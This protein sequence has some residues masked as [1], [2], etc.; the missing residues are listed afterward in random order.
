MKSNGFCAFRKNILVKIVS[1]LLVQTFLF[2]NISFATIDDRGVSAKTDSA[3]VVSLDNIGISTQ[4]GTIK[5]RYRGK[6]S[7]LIIHIQD[8]H[9]NY[10]AQT[11]ISKILEE[12]IKNY[13]ID[14]VAVEGA[15]GVVDT[16]WFKAFPDAEIRRE[17]ADYFMKKGEITGAEF[18]S[19]TSDYP[20]TIYGAENRDYYV[21]NLN[22]FLESYP[23]KDE[24]VKYYSDVKTALSRFKKYIY[25]KELAELDEK[26][27]EHKRKEI[28]FADYARYLGGLAKSKKIDTNQYENFKI[29]TETLKLEKDINFD[30][31]NEERA[32]LIDKL[33][34]TLEKDKLSELVNKSLEFK[35]GKID[36]NKFYAFLAELAKE[37]KIS[38]TEEYNNLARY[39]IY[40]RIY[41]K[42]EHEKLF[43]E[44]ESLV[45][46]IKERMFVNDDQRTLD[47]FWTN[48]N[49]II[50]FINIELS[51]KEYEYYLANKQD[52]A[53][54]KFIDFINKNAT[55]FGLAYEAKEAPSELT[56]VFPKL[57]D[58]YEIALKRDD[59]LLKNVL[60]GMDKSK[61]KAAVLITGGFHT[62]GISNLLE[63]KGLSYLVIS[64]VIT[65]DAESPYI[66]VL[67]GQKTPFEELLVET[68]KETSKLATWLLS[69]LF[70]EHVR[71]VLKTR[72]AAEFKGAWTE[73]YVHEWF[74]DVL[75]AL[76]RQGVKVS[77]RTIVSG[78]LVDSVR[79]GIAR[80]NRDKRKPVIDGESENRIV[81]IIE[82]RIDELFAEKADTAVKE[83]AQTPQKITSQ[84]DASGYSAK[85]SD[86]PQNGGDTAKRAPTTPNLT[87]EENERL[88]SIVDREKEKS[89]GAIEYVDCP[90]E[91]LQLIKNSPTRKKYKKDLLLELF[92]S[93]K[94][95]IGLIDK[96]KELLFSRKQARLLGV[97]CFFDRRRDDKR[98]L[99]GAL[100]FTREFW[101][102]FVEGDEAN[103][104][105]DP[106]FTPVTKYDVAAA[107]VHEFASK[108]QR[109]AEIGTRHSF[110]TNAELCVNS[111][112]ADKR[113]LSD[114]DILFLTYAVE[115]H[116]IDYLF[117]ALRQYKPAKD[118]TDSFN[119]A[120]N[121]TIK[122][123]AERISNEEKSFAGLRLNETR[124]L[125]LFIRHLVETGHTL[126]EIRDTLLKLRN[127]DKILSQEVLE[128]NVFQ[129]DWITPGEEGFVFLP[130]IKPRT[131][132]KDFAKIELPASKDLE[133]KF[134]Q[135]IGEKEKEAEAR[136]AAYINTPE[137]DGKSPQAKLLELRTKACSTD[138]ARA[139]TE[140]V[141]KAKRTM[142]VVD[143]ADAQNK[144]LLAWNTPEWGIYDTY[145]TK[146]GNE[147]SMRRDPLDKARKN[148]AMLNGS[149]MADLI[150]RQIMTKRLEQVRTGSGHE[151]QVIMIAGAGGQGKSTLAQ[152]I[153]KKLKAYIKQNPTCGLTDKDMV[154][155]GTDHHLFETE[156]RYRVVF[157]ENG[158]KE[159][160]P[161]IIGG[162][163]YE[164]GE[165]VGDLN[166]LIHGGDE[167]YGVPVKAKGTDKHAGTIT[168][169]HPINPVPIIIVE[170][171]TAINDPQ[172]RNNIGTLIIGIVAESDKTRLEQK[173][174][175]DML[176]IEEGGT[177]GLTEREIVQDALE[178]MI[179]EKNDM[180]A[181]DMEECADIIW[182]PDTS[183]ILLR[184]HT[185]RSFILANRYKWLCNEVKK[186]LAKQDLSEAV[187]ETEA[188]GYIDTVVT[189]AMDKRAPETYDLAVEAIVEVVANQANPG[190]ALK[191]LG[192]LVYEL[193]DQNK[194]KAFHAMLNAVNRIVQ[195]DIP[196]EEAKT[197]TYTLAAHVSRSEKANWIIRVLLSPGV[198]THELGHMAE[199]LMKGRLKLKDIRLSHL[200]KGIPGEVRGPP[201]LA[202]ME[203]NLVFGIALPLLYSYFFQ[204][205]PTLLALYFTANLCVLILDITLPVLSMRFPGVFPS[206]YI[207]QSDLYNLLKESVL[208]YELNESF[209]E[210]FENEKSVLESGLPRKLIN[211]AL[212]VLE[213]SGRKA[214]VKKALKNAAS[215]YPIFARGVLNDAIQYLPDE[216]QAVIISI[217]QEIT[218][219][220]AASKKVVTLIPVGGRG[221]GF[222]PF[223]WTVLKPFTKLFGKSNVKYAAERAIATGTSPKDIFFII[224]EEMIKEAK[225]EVEG[226]GI[227]E[228][229]FIP[230]Y[231]GIDSEGNTV[232]LEKSALLG[233]AAVYISRLRG[234]DTVIVAERS[235]LVLTPKKG[236]MDELKTALERA[237]T[238]AYLEPTVAFLGNPPTEEEL[239]AIASGQKT[240]DGNKGYIVVNPNLGTAMEGVYSV[241]KFHEKP[242]LPDG[243]A[244]SDT[245]KRYLS[246]KASYNA[247]MFIFRADYLLKMF[248]NLRP[249]DY[250]KLTEL[251][252]SI[253]MES[254]REVTQSVYNYFVSDAHK[255][256]KAQIHTAFEKS[257]V[258]AIAPVEGNGPKQ[259]GV[260]VA[261]FGQAVAQEWVGGQGSLRAVWPS[262]KVGENYIRPNTPAAVANIEIGNGVTGCNILLNEGD[263]DTHVHVK[264]AKG[265]AIAYEKDKKAL[266]VAP[267]KSSKQVKGITEFVRGSELLGAFAE[268]SIKS[269]PKA[270]RTD[271]KF[272]TVGTNVETLGLN[273]F[274]VIQASE[275][276][277]VYCEQ[278]IVGM[279]NAENTIVISC[280]EGSGR[281]IYVYGPDALYEGMVKLASVTDFAKEAKTRLTA[282][283]ASIERNEMTPALAKAYA[284]QMGGSKEDF[285]NGKIVGSFRIC[286]ANT[287][288]VLRDDIEALALL[289][290]H[291]NEEIA[292]AAYPSWLYGIGNWLSDFH[293]QREM[294]VHDRVIAQ[295]LQVARKVSG[296][297]WEKLDKNLTEY[298]LMSE[299]D[300][301][302]LHAELGKVQSLAKRGVTDRE[303]IKKIIVISRLKPG[304]DIAMNSVIFT[305]VKRMLPHAEIVFVGAP[306]GEDL[307]GGD[308]AIRLIPIKQ[309]KETVFAARA[310]NAGA[311]REAVENELRGLQKGEEALVFDISVRNT[312]FGVFPALP[313][314]TAPRNYMYYE[315]I[316]E[317]DVTLSEEIDRWLYEIF[318]KEQGSAF[319]R[320]Y[321]Y[322]SVGPKH[323]QLA[324][325]ILRAAHLENQNF[326]TLTLGTGGDESK[327]ISVQFE[328]DLVQ[329]IL[330]TGR[331]VIMSKGDRRE[332]ERVNAVVSEL[333]KRHVAVGHIDGANI[334][335]VT[336]TKTPKVVTVSTTLGGFSALIGKSEQLIC[337]SSAPKHIGGALRVP[338]VVIYLRE[339]GVHDKWIPYTPSPVDVV[340]V[341]PEEVGSKSPKLLA[342]RIAA[343]AMRQKKLAELR[344]TFIS[345]ETGNNVVRYDWGGEGNALLLGKPGEN[346]AE[347]W[348]Y[349]TIP[350]GDKKLPDV[351]AGTAISVGTGEEKVE[352]APITFKE[353]VET[354][355]EIL[356]KRFESVPYFTKSLSPRTKPRVYIAFNKKIEEEGALSEFR[357]ASEIE[358]RL[359][360]ELMGSFKEGLTEA[361]FKNEFLKNY[362]KW[363]E[364]QYDRGWS[365][366]EIT[367]AIPEEIM[368]PGYDRTLWERMRKNR[369][370]L[371]SFFLHTELKDGQIIMAPAGD[372]RGG[373]LHR[374]VGSFQM[375]PYGSHPDAKHE[376]WV[377]FSAGKNPGGEEKFAT[378]EIMNMSDVTLSPF[379][380]DSPLSYKNGKVVPRKNLCGKNLLAIGN[381]VPKA[382]DDSLE[383]ALEAEVE[384]IDIMI[385]ALRP[386]GFE[387]ITSFDITSQAGDVTS[388]YQHVE[389]AKAQSVIEGTYPV[390]PQ[391]L[392]VMH[393]LTLSGKGESEKAKISVEPRGAKGDFEQLLVTKG[394]VTVAR[395]GEP[396]ETL[397][398]GQA[399]FI[400]ADVKDVYTITASSEAE[401]LR[402]YPGKDIGKPVNETEV[403]QKGSS[404]EEGDNG[405]PVA[406]PEEGA[407]KTEEELIV[408]KG[409]DVVKRVAQAFGA[410]LATYIG[411]PC[412][413]FI[414]QGMNL[415]TKEVR[416]YVED[417]YGVKNISKLRVVAFSRLDTLVGR[418]PK[419]AHAII[420]FDTELDRVRRGAQ[421][422]IV[423]GIRDIIANSPI[424]PVKYQERVRGKAC[425]YRTEILVAGI[426]AA[427]TTKENIR[428]RD[429]LALK[430]LSVIHTL[431]DRDSI[432]IDDLGDLLSAKGSDDNALAS[433]IDRLVNTLLLDMPA[434]PVDID[435]RLNNE[436]D[437]QYSV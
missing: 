400:P 273:G 104:K 44:I 181:N 343:H 19:I 313:A 411:E 188:V 141:A 220:A 41:S 25:S 218:K 89:M 139:A 209:K 200:F 383:A 369:E 169:G 274:S 416:K 217:A 232:A 195:V 430:L 242:S 5:N 425:I 332:V 241:A 115:T 45:G 225:K 358:R 229:N 182:E 319:R 38:L 268:P 39:I 170:G 244:D 175:R 367:P 295:T 3:S 85:D 55:R 432:T 342:N 95:R 152:G 178:K 404:V 303:K 247:S 98:G 263:T 386:E 63:E 387:D 302:G 150:A 42:I 131:P 90:E 113:D 278:G 109:S 336:E 24:F 162:G 393:K 414:Q 206:R 221:A 15:D 72:H 223:S 102:R 196:A 281:H 190:L 49:T 291:R 410:N 399:I 14:F 43:D 420:A 382:K 22:S 248:A 379:D 74:D 37:Q 158:R 94:V 171:V 341:T 177:R 126:E 154:I 140:A 189:Y 422:E 84:E 73:E 331:N 87:A 91:V 315:E 288:G 398:N 306:N 350:T 75:P 346:I 176:P 70:A 124:R 183:R 305:K 339:E 287:K 199:G 377:T 101:R 429:D 203:S 192:G 194:Q 66:S 328:A 353:L 389:N 357:K 426:M 30:T 228:E 366:S 216:Y 427:H 108:F 234:P 92:Q 381:R 310:L 371:V 298:G 62:K 267:V 153:C 333:E 384:A 272:N 165:M 212:M 368:K 215:R 316:T 356:G 289:I 123:L 390:Q 186:A 408:E 338:T 68:E 424:L 133:K 419:H 340:R 155:I 207:Y 76:G 352:L 290:T 145:L 163:M 275:N 118:I 243:K 224:E 396:A 359:I 134:L 227:P 256:R 406:G 83:S 96:G 184:R 111:P 236:V 226:M 166:E 100:Y 321:A 329:N 137:A 180:L 121:D 35:L 252:S 257:I 208:E 97:L 52:F 320:S 239:R 161:I 213:A 144:S 54:D 308:N 409:K 318:D 373:I 413:V 10:E 17:V 431:S 337:Y 394:T 412:T 77:D 135:E 230:E 364:E 307:Y 56:Y 59:I 374:I 348:H 16:S 86:T 6:D 132:I 93:H 388:R 71:G 264:G 127:E 349:F 375:H 372:E 23:Y 277:A 270:P 301:A 240:A 112:A 149:K 67:T 335:A 116:N 119:R 253:G 401:V 428:E 138:E 167:G 142:L 7:R 362:D 78:L 18:L 361:E 380:F 255:G 317:G 197:R 251:Y 172:L 32:Q 65:K 129:Y 9:C 392:W 250:V 48:V 435:Q 187:R 279:T 12:L 174:P 130:E 50:G 258:Q 61:A 436:R 385:N 421:G 106:Y 323:N 117:Y 143:W 376:S 259:F 34:K 210:I 81:N 249:E 312:H 21:K 179:W 314:A 327:Q 330:A 219:E 173:V 271:K 309:A 114:L 324:D 103:K 40:A 122:I 260:A 157:G 105:H 347:I 2:Y 417:V 204:S 214:L 322:A 79:K 80:I 11:N 297:P 344:K 354:Y 300:M 13:H 26:I 211:A 46:D 299:E 294:L 360:Y 29:L 164:M 82:R 296:H 136:I 282:I 47:R 231:K 107:I 156:V 146:F 151:K 160:M 185:P 64:P 402:S 69:D 363:V 120:L 355:P 326:V 159:R 391:E 235:D 262:E 60:N 292:K 265:L 418:I 147:V 245:M 304:G 280:L 1:I 351:I 8:A 345:E 246:E 125:T 205:F 36:N 405:G 31:V 233:F 284:E 285:E 27:T 370:K 202:G 110:A 193:Q 53:P 33:S 88:F 222:A 365:A 238:I 99:Y 28:Q 57:V 20:F 254:E 311:V 269:L 395:V 128:E 58:F 407:G 276:C 334:T 423:D 4:I 237:E 437:I 403:P 293:S 325:E 434:Q 198:I 168:Q 261:P 378:A 283:K 191:A 148:Y 397:K 201:V 286:Y 266:I 433:R 415:N 51:N